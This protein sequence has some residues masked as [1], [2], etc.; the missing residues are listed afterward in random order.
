MRGSVRAVGA[1]CLSSVAVG[2]IIAIRGD[3]VLEVD[4]VEQESRET[5]RRLEVS[6]GVRVSVSTKRGRMWLIHGSISSDRDG[7]NYDIGFGVVLMSG[8]GSHP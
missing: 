8:Q 5:G 3:A 1:F 6:V 7:S 4:E 2:L